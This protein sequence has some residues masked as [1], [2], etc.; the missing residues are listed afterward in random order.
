VCWENDGGGGLLPFTE[1]VLCWAYVANSNLNLF[2][3]IGPV[4]VKCN[5]SSFC[6]PKILTH[7]LSFHFYPS[8]LGNE[9]IKL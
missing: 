4:S 2:H 1:A 5:S 3:G 6:T 7:P 9:C 8:Y